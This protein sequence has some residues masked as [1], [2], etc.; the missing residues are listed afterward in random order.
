MNRAFAV[1]AATL[2]LGGCAT[3]YAPE[4][5][6]DVS[7]DECVILPAKISYKLTRGLLNIE[8]EEG[9]AAGRYKAEKEDASGTFYR[10]VSRPLFQGNDMAPGQYTVKAGGVWLPKQSAEKPRLYSYFEAENY[11]TND[12]NAY[13]NQV[14][15]TSA[16]QGAGVGPSVAGAAIGGAIVGAMIQMDVGKIFLW[17]EITD[18]NFIAQVSK[19]R[20][21][22]DNVAR[23]E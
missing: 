1:V 18:V 5:L 6:A 14:A 2:C 20:A 19:P 7:K 12:L 9:L 16:S 17:Q 3:G 13:T 11:S 22:S 21:C 23:N 10:G 15:M 4:K 8:W